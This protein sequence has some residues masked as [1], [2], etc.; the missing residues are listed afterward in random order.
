M[1]VA[2]GYGEQKTL[3]I[4][5]DGPNGPRA[6]RSGRLFIGIREMIGATK[7]SSRPGRSVAGPRCCGALE[8]RRPK[9]SVYETASIITLFDGSLETAVR[10]EL[11]VNSCSH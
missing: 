7:L 6:L 8:E 3:F 2:L 5:L 1:R 9:S 10:L 11:S 4:L